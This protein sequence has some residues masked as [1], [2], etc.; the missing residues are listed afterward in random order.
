M[1]GE[2]EQRNAE[3]NV[4]EDHVVDCSEDEEKDSCSEAERTVDERRLEE[5]KTAPRPTT[6]RKIRSF[7]KL[8]NSYQ[9]GFRRLLP[10]QRR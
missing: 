2:E 3:V 6:K 9:V 10:F 5:I 1:P 7:L 4:D 8:F